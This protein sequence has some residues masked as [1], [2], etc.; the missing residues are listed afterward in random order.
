MSDNDRNKSSP[1]DTFAEDLG[2]AVLVAAAASG[3]SNR[4]SLAALAAGSSLSPDQLTA[5]IEQTR[6]L[7]DCVNGYLLYL[8]GVLSFGRIETDCIAL[9]RS[10]CVSAFNTSAVRSS[11]FSHGIWGR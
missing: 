1:L 5:L 9:D 2:R 3:E 10:L 8:T 7:R 4:L 11:S 6:R